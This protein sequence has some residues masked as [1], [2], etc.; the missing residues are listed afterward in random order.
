MGLGP[1]ACTHCRVVAD[2]VQSAEHPYG[3]WKCPVCNTSELGSMWAAHITWEE[4]DTNLKFYKFM[5]GDKH[6]P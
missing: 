6:G 2:L 1:A 3:E 5:R 4:S